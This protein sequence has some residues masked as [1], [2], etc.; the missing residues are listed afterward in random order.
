MD[1]YFIFFESNEISMQNNEIQTV[2]NFSDCFVAVI[3]N[4]RKK[5]H[6]TCKIKIFCG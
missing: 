3:P 6:K 2:L 1:F 5:S 4:L